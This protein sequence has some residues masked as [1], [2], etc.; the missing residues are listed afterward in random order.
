MVIE[1][2]ELRFSLRF[3]GA[4]GAVILWG[5]MPAARA[6]ADVGGPDRAGAIAPKKNHDAPRVDSFVGIEPAGTAGVLEEAYGGQRATDWLV[7]GGGG[8]GFRDESPQHP[9]STADVV[10]RRF[11]L[12]TG[13]G[14]A[15]FDPLPRSAVKPVAAVFAGVGHVGYDV[16]GAL[17]VLD[18]KMYVVSPEA[19]LAATP[20]K[21]VRID[22]RAIGRFF[23]GSALAHELT[24]DV[25][26]WTGVV[27][28]TVVP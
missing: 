3:G 10:P 23:F 20:S 9:R 27:S 1:H 15:A 18:E 21:N 5:A 22:A 19:G 6:D 11:S 4:I 7:I 14:Y 13:G 8:F 28:V 16:R 17:P 12:G 2:M 24:R 25:A 26:G